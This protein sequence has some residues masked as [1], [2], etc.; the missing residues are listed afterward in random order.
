MRSIFFGGA[1]GAGPKTGSSFANRF[2]GFFGGTR[3]LTGSAT[4]VAFDCWMVFTGTL[5]VFPS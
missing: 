2:R 1:V 4:G 5:N 3:V